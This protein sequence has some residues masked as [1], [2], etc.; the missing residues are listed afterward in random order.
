MSVPLLFFFVADWNYLG[1]NGLVCLSVC[2]RLNREGVCL[3]KCD[4]YIF[5]D[6]VVCT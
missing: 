6:L 5:L 3:L 4:N 2:W 1:A